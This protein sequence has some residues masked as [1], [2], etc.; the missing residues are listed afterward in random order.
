[1]PSII[2]GMVER[3]VNADI[4]KEELES[5]STVLDPIGAGSIRDEDWT[6]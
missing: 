3:I 4:E 2:A 6:G 1:M 5:L